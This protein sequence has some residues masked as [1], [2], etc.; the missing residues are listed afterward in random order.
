MIVNAE[1]RD[2]DLEMLRNPVRRPFDLEL[3]RDDV[4]D[5]AGVA[6]AFGDADGDDR[7]PRVDRFVG[8]NAL[9]IGVDDASRDGMA[10]DLAHQRGLALCGRR[11]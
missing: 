8:R 1:R 4:H 11:R 7:E 6:D 5:G 9:Q 10:L 3:V 2:V